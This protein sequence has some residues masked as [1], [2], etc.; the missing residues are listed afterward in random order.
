MSRE[1]PIAARV[2]RRFDAPPE[3]VFDAWLDPA[4]LGRWMFGPAVREEEVVSLSLDPRVGGGFSFV[5]RRGEAVI[6]RV[7]R[8]REIVR[9]LLLVFTWGIA[10]EPH[11]ESKVI[12]EIRPSGNGSELTLTHEM[13]PRWLEFVGRSEEAWRKMLD[14]LD[15]ALS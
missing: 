6:D 11:G 3:R 2:V 9:P 14:A 5:V 12:V 7:G 4:Q 13:A 10:G 8:Y 15:A 1:S